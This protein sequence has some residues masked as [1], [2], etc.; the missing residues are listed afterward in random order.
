[1]TVLPFGS[2]GAGPL[3][4]LVH[5]ASERRCASLRDQG[6]TPF[7]PLNDATSPY[8]LPKT[9]RRAVCAALSPFPSRES[10]FRLLTFLA[11]FWTHPS[12]LER[13]FPI[14]RRALAD[15]RFLGLAEGEVRGGLRVLEKAGV[16]VREP[17]ERRHAYRRT[18]DG[19]RRSP[20][21][22]RF[23]PLFQAMFRAVNRWKALRDQRAEKAKAANPEPRDNN[24]YILTPE[25]ILTGS[26]ER[27]SERTVAT[28]PTSPLEAALAALGRAILK[29]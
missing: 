6:R 18:E 23:A 29:T 7:R 17:V 20:V 15:H 4:L 8:R 13:S 16:V 5:P 26:D 11:R 9:A 10:A 24:R 27:V 3:T 14:D 22:F 21:L 12:R 25:V 19:L 1:M 28:D 2:L